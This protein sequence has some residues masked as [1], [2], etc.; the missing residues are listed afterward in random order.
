MWLVVR[1]GRGELNLRISYE[2]FLAA[3]KL[4]SQMHVPNCFV[5]QQEA[6]WAFSLAAGGTALD[7]SETFISELRAIFTSKVTYI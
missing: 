1:G 7:A 3:I 2:E 6:P 4:A 5:C